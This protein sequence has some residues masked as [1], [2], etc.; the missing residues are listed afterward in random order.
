L[1]LLKVVLHV[2][3]IYYNVAS[4]WQQNVLVY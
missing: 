3:A 2:K 4:Q 1:A